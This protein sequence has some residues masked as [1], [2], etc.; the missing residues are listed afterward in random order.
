[1]IYEKFII[2][3]IKIYKIWIVL[4]LRFILN[5]YGVGGGGGIFIFIILILFSFFFILFFICL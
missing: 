4:N 5:I 1:M 3:V 2:Y